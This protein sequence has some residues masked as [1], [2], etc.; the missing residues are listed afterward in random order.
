MA[1]M[2][3]NAAP[4][5]MITFSLYVANASNP[6]KPSIATILR[7]HPSSL[8]VSSFAIIR[9]RRKSLIGAQSALKATNHSFNSRDFDEHGNSIIQNKIIDGMITI[10]L[11]NTG[12]MEEIDKMSQFCIDAFYNDDSEG[13]GLFSRK[14]KDIRLTAL[15][16]AQI[17]D[18]LL[19]HSGNRCVY[20]AKKSNK[21]EVH[22]IVGCCE[23]IEERLD[24]SPTP[25]SKGAISERERNK[26]A[27]RRPLIENL[28]VKKEYRRSG[29]GVALLKACEESVRSWV[30]FHDEV[31]TQVEVENDRAL[32]FFERCGYQKLFEDSTCKRIVIDGTIFI[33]EAPVTKIMLRKK[34]S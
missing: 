6:S 17:M 32:R 29:I 28:S 5:L 3:I 9:R 30:P 31:F 23:V 20:I 24:V 12:D 4:L 33:K 34:L 15:Q 1:Y 13:M 14:W 27:R 26:T 25:T 16:K 8:F 7:P 10:Q 19:P 2:A 11:I 18:L 21:N 22:E